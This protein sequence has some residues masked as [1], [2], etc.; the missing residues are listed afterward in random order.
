MF[1][2]TLYGL[3]KDGTIKVW[4]I[5]TT[6]CHDGTSVLTVI[7]GKEGGKM[8]D[9]HTVIA[10]G[11]QK[12][13][14]SEQAVSEAQGKI[15]KQIDKGY[16]ETKEELGKLPLLAML[17]GDFRKI[18]HRIN[19]EAGVDLSDK[20]DGVRCVAKCEYLGV[21]TLE[22]RTGQP[23]VLPH[24]TKELAW[25]M[26]PGDQVDGEIYLHGYALQ[27]ITS[28]VKRTDPDKEVEKTYKAYNK[29]PSD[30]TYAEHEEAVRI[31]ELRPKL[32]FVIFDIP[33]D[34]PWH[35]R[36]EDLKA[37]QRDRMAGAEKVS[38]LQYK[39][40]FSEVEMKAAHKDAVARGF[41]GVMLRT[42]GGLYESGK[43]SSDLQKYKTM[44]DAEFLILDVVSDKQGDG[45]YVCQ[46]DLNELTFQVVMGSLPDRTAALKNKST[47]V[48]K[49]MT[50][51][52]QSRY[53]GTL[54]PQFPA[55]KLIR[56]GVVKNGH[57]IPTE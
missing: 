54:L 46:N 20:L 3:E 10:E 1:K 26:N 41:E 33:S 18:G 13:T 44:L 52:F 29:N 42:H 17:A 47:F 49:Y 39:R 7:H 14:V 45:V 8:Q 25:Y 23:Y 12:R 11:K 32:E 16:R 30:E 27:E 43:R 57:F 50:I 56:E 48:G 28:A 15:K 5:L 35:Q 4:E 19:W 24:I 31:Q 55:G 22:S 2:K 40:V 37:F 21:V 9:K 36:L 53:K 34:K 38:V 51:A 6:D